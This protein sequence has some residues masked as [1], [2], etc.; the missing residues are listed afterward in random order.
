MLI[1]QIAADSAFSSSVSF[2]PL[3]IKTV[4]V[5]LF[6]VVLAIVAIRYFVPRLSGYRR[7]RDSMIQIVDMQ[8]LDARRAI[9][10]VKIG[11]KQI[12]VGMTEHS[13]TYLCEVAS[14]RE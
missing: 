3:F 5:T 1:A 6:V 10:I 7:N 12:A 9:G 2:L 11:D 14:G 4:L 13:L 8:P